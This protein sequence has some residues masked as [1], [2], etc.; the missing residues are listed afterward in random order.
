MRSKDKRR[1]TV[2]I[3]D[4]NPVERRDD[5][6]WRLIE[7]S[8]VNPISGCIEWAGSTA[9]DGYGQMKVNGKT[10]GVHRWMAHLTLGLDID[11]K[12]CACHHCDN[13]KCI[14]PEHL[15]VG[16]QKENMIDMMVKGRA[17][18]KRSEY[19]IRTT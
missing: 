6:W 3:D 9:S 4:L 18:R 11:S 12:L 7:K 17:R 5:I 10:M 8:E 16:T 15:F 19:L 13:R 1:R 14:N 2:F